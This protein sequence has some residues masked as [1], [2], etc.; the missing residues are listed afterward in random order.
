[1]KTKKIIWW[2]ILGV[3]LVAVLAIVGL[4]VLFPEK[5]EA[6]VVQ[7]KLQGNQEWIEIYKR[8]QNVRQKIQETPENEVALLVNE[9]F[10]WKT[11]GDLTRDN[12]FYQKALDTYKEGIE[13]S[14][15]KNIAFYWNA[16]KVAENMNDFAMA[17]S[18]YREAIRI[19]PSYNE[20]YRYLAELYILKMKKSDQEVL[21]VYADGLKGTSGD[22]SIFLEQ[23]SYLRRV[24]RT[25]DA[26]DC[27]ELLV[28]SYP[29]NKLFVQTVDELKKQISAT[30]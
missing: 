13:K 17:E 27:Y 25:K 2:S 4:W 21:Q 18:M 30:P 9:A 20:S 10:E 26:I 14:E 15:G 24:N 6:W 3:I 7:K 5:K 28:K 12:Y 1:M 22:A 8:V 23:C 11:L 19:S 16:G 29:D